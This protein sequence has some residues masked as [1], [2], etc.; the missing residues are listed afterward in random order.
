M[1]DNPFAEP[2]DDNRT[3]IRPN[4]GGR[5]PAA[6]GPTGGDTQ[7]ELPSQRRAAASQRA[8]GAAVPVAEGTEKIPGGDDVLIAAATP[9]LLFMAR[10]RN[11]ANPPDAGDLYQRTVRQIRAFEQEARDKGVPLEQL[12][13][14]HYAICAS[15]DDV[16]LNTP[17]GNSGS[18]AE[19]SLVST[20]HQEVRSGERFFDV[21]KQ[22]CANPGRFLP[23]IKLMYLCM[24]LGFVGQYRLSRRGLGDLNRI[25]EETY[26]VIVRHQAQADADLAP[27][28]KGVNAP[29]RPVRFTVPVWVAGV[30]GL[31]ILGGL[32]T[33]FSLS[34]N[35]VS[36]TV[37]A[38]LQNAPP[39]HMPAITRAPF[40]EAQPVAAVTPPPPPPEPST[41]DKLRQF[42]KPE[43]DQ[44]LVEVL[45]T[46]A[47]PKVRITGKGM[48]ASGS[49]NL[50]PSF[51]PLLDRIGL[52]LKEEVGPV[53]VIGY[54]DNE[55]IRTVAFPSNFQLSQ[56]RADAASKIIAATIGDPSR[57]STEGRADAD[58][59][60]PNTTPEGR[61]RNRRIEIV[62]TRQ[63]F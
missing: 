37:Y 57:L 48:F 39:D 20:F 63:G 23:V 11:T 55:P 22:M 40:I 14:A 31:G 54:T 7:V 24:S 16:V 10:L 45:G 28:T 21:L 9:L 61:E 30:V 27:H 18:W 26:A 43:V 5:R 60:A 2:D 53:K 34:L 46:P 62:L 17:W 13:P 25:R 15:L 12:R 1:S 36:D 47:Q 29:Y 52:A 50:Q 42:L 32:F 6:A 49:A 41:L 8:A 51:K 4:P 38:R 59:I 44:G 35:T 3:I 58:P 33:W 19:R 56:A